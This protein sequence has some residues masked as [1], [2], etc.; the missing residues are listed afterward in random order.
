L[1]AI[2]AGVLSRSLR[3]RGLSPCGVLDDLDLS[4]EPVEIN[5]IDD[6]LCR[7]G[8]KLKS[9]NNFLRFIPYPESPDNA[10]LLPDRLDKSI[11][12]VSE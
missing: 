1:E 2:F 12:L 9:G 3:S 11:D 10:R 7:L 4:V 8:V 5:F 6:E